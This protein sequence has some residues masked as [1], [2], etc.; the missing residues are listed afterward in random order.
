MRTSL[1]AALFLAALSGCAT[2]HHNAGDLALEESRCPDVPACQRSRV[3]AVLVK[4]IDP[5]DVAGMEKLHQGLVDGGFAKVYRIELH[6]LGFIAEEASRILCE[7][8]EA[9]FVVV[10]CG[11]GAPMARAVAGRLANRGATVDAV[12]EIAPLPG[13]GSAV[14]PAARH[15]VIDRTGIRAYSPGMSVEFRVVPEIGRL[16]PAAH[17]VVIEMVKDE[18]ANSARS[19]ETIEAAPVPTLPLLDNPAPLPGSS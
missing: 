18:L 3:Y 14:V 6:H 5:L 15:V 9:R 19:V 10:G 13:V 12:V 4:G 16:T 17:P 2:C 1:I 7:Q 11:S 8:P